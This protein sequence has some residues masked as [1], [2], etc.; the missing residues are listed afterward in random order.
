MTC[1]LTDKSGSEVHCPLR[2]KNGRVQ[3]ESAQYPRKRE[4]QSFRRGMTRAKGD[5]QSCA[6]AL[7]F[8]LVELC[9]VVMIALVIAGIA[10]PS[11]ITTWD[12]LQ[13][14][15]AS[16]EVSDLMQRT[17]IQAAKS[18]ATY[19]IRYQLNAG[20]Q[21]VFIDLNN[22][23]ALDTGEPYIDLGQGITAATSAP[24]GS[25]GQPTPYVLTGDSSTGS[26]CS[27][28]C[29]LA[30]S[31]RG[32]PCNYTSPPTCATPAASYFVYYFQDGRPNGWAAVYVTK[33]GRS[34]S[35]IW[36]GTSW[37]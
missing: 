1:S 2:Q 17:R 27:N 30:Y 24:S 34:Q 33:A 32:L 20:V 28:A 12:D 6:S 37:H 23:G 3:T 31:P 5:R 10:I 16:S 11:A 22:N 8:S 14:R 13:L 15:S 26:P 29:V 36:N 9:V 35:L 21:R 18:N 7:G 4:M 25:N 19:P